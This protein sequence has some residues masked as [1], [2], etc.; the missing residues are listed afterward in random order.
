MYI[1]V[2]DDGES[3]CAVMGWDDD[4]DGAICATCGDV[5]V[6]ESRKDALK[7]IRISK[8][9]AKLCV[10]QGKMANS[11]FLGDAAKCIDIRKLKAREA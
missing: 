5:A 9:F 4:C 1:V 7:A 6:F 8:A 11:D 3:I 10:E 2:Y